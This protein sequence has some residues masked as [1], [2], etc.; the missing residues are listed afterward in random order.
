MKY[1]EIQK[2][3][4]EI[5]SM[6]YNFRYYFDKPNDAATMTKVLAYLYNTSRIPKDAF[7]DTEGLS[8]VIRFYDAENKKRTV[9]EVV[10]AKTIGG[11]FISLQFWASEPV[12][13]FVDEEE[14][15]DVIRRQV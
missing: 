6:E 2:N 9:A 8:A 13:E 15:A 1:S 5:I 14:L 3:A 7:A 10:C 11:Y 4:K 12:L